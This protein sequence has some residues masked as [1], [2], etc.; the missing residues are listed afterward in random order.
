MKDAGAMDTPVGV[1]RASNAA[2]KD[3]ADR[4]RD[5]LERL[6]GECEIDPDIVDRA[7]RIA[8]ADQSWRDGLELL[9]DDEDVA[10][11]LK[12]SKGSVAELADSDELIV[13]TAPDGSARYPAYQFHD[14]MSSPSLARAH[15]VL[16]DS[17]YVSPW[18]AS[19]WARTSHP[20]LESRSPAQWAG[21]RR[22]DALLLLV[23]ERDAAAAAR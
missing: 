13:L 18:S 12:L 3:A 11:L 6:V 15:R 1:D 19:S 21:E 23:A 20:E 4:F 9:L 14:G 17:G 8:A 22:D 7:A 5:E 16:V 2:A 10:R